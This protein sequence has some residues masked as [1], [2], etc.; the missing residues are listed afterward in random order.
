MLRLMMSFALAG[1]LLAPAV[2]AADPGS[3]CLQS[4]D[5][6]A[7]F[8]VTKIAG[9][10][11]D[12]VDAGKELCYRC[13]YGQSPMVMVFTR[14]TDG[15]LGK[16][17]KAIDSAVQENES[18]KLK[19]L[20][21]FLGE[22]RDRVENAASK[23]AKKSGAKNIPFVVASDLESG[24]SRYKISEDAAVTVV[25]ANESKVVAAH[26]FTKASDINVAAVVGAVTE[27]LN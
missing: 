18:E 27:M 16:L 1:L 19:G 25:V 26:Q 6:I 10:E 21:T 15:K 23:F 3:D 2:S 12:G 7:P 14:S 20:V 11:G 5:G 22:D 8:T 17:V 4:G 13:R 9:A 24:P